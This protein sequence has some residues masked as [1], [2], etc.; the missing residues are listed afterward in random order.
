MLSPGQERALT[1]R[2]HLG[3]VRARELLVL[4]NL[5]LANWAS[6]RFAN[7]LGEDGFQIAIVGLIWAVDSYDPERGARFATYAIWK[8][9]CALERARRRT[10][11]HIRLPAQ[12]RQDMPDLPVTRRLHSIERE[13]LRQCVPDY[14]DF[15][16][17]IERCDAREHAATLVGAGLDSIRERDAFILR[18]RA[19]GDSLHTIAGV[20]NVTRERV[21]QLEGR[22]LRGLAKACGAKAP[23]MASMASFLDEQQP[24]EEP[25]P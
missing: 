7:D 25:T 23:A 19:S 6:A 24:P 22:A 16:S 4:H 2:A 14:R 12:W 3:D 5:R 18:R 17:D 13:N 20:L 11:D 10:V 1:T 9:R 15:M 21:R 8:I